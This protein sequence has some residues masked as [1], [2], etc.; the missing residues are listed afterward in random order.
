MSIT[1]CSFLLTTVNKLQSEQKNIIFFKYD[2]YKI[3]QLGKVDS[4][5]N[6]IVII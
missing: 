2:L 4:N 6:I 3:I 5:Y 1:A